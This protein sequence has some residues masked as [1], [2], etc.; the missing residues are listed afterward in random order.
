MHGPVVLTTDLDCFLNSIIIFYGP[1]ASLIPNKGT[2][3]RTLIQFRWIQFLIENPNRT[4][5]FLDKRDVGSLARPF[6]VWRLVG[7]STRIGTI[8]DIGGVT[9]SFG[10]QL[11]WYIAREYH[12]AS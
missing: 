11:I 3:F 6:L 8:P 7:Y 2:S 1:W 10:P 12:R 9:H 4:S 5:K